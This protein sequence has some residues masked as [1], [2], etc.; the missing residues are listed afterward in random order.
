MLPETHVS[1]LPVQDSQL[2]EK[3]RVVDPLLELRPDDIPNLI[4]CWAS[5][6]SLGKWPGAQKP[7]PGPRRQAILAAA[8]ASRDCYALLLDKPHERLGLPGVRRGPENALDEI[9]GV[10][11]AVS[12][13]CLQLLA[14]SRTNGPRR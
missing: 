2:R 9:G 13:E 1:F 7:E 3:R 4:D 10:P 8:V 14:T 11:N 5:D 12:K 6:L